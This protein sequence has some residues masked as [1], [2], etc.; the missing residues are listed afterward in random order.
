MTRMRCSETL[1]SV[2]LDTM[3]EGVSTLIVMALISL[4]YVSLC[5]Y[6]NVMIALSSIDDKVI[7]SSNDFFFF[8]GGGRYA[9]VEMCIWKCS[10]W[11]IIIHL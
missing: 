8:W 9:F 4:R 10:Q 1:E 3:H 5:Q 7:I 6:N 11:A 2:S